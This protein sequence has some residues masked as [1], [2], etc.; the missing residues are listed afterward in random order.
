[1][2]LLFSFIHTVESFYER[3]SLCLASA[4]SVG[5]NSDDGDRDPVPLSGHAHQQELCRRPG[6]ARH[7]RPRRRRR[8]LS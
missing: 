3:Q 2:N 5:V 6:G 1:M 8:R 4:D 7:L